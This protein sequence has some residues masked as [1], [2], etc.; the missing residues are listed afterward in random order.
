MKGRL[1]AL[2]PLIVGEGVDGLELDGVLRFV[3]AELTA[4]FFS[5]VLKLS[6]SDTP[7]WR[8]KIHTTE[9][10]LYVLV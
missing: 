8:C 9:F 10:I 5:A 7:Y 3:H 1:C 6:Y 4:A 2:L